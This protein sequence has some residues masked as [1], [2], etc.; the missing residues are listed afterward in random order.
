MMQ[1]IGA[2]Y[3]YSL[4]SLEIQLFSDFKDVKTP[5]SKMRTAKLE[6]KYEVAGDDA[7]LISCH[8]SLIL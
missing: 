3:S 7:A 2:L 1:G 8:A 4:N 6:C 5:P